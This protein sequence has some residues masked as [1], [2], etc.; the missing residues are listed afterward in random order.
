MKKV[1]QDDPSP[2]LFSPATSTGGTTLIRFQRSAQSA[3]AKGAEARQWSKEITDYINSRFPESRLQVFSERF[4]EINTIV[5]QVDLADLASLDKYQA[6]L[7]SDQGYWTIL[8]KSTDLFM[9]G[10]ILDRVLETL[11]WNGSLAIIKSG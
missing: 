3:L 10:S 7:N 8:N 11:W 9:E 1:A 2:S 5:W 4:G 6:N